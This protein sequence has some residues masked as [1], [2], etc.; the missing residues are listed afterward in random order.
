MRRADWLIVPLLAMGGV[1]TGVAGQAPDVV[2]AQPSQSRSTRTS[3]RCYRSTV[4]GAIARERSR[5]CRFSPTRAVSVGESHQDGRGQQE[6]AAW[7]CRPGARTLLEQSKWSTHDEI[8]TL[9]RWV[10]E[11]AVLGEPAAAPASVKWP[12]GWQITPDKIV[13]AGVY[14]PGKG[15]APSPPLLARRIGRARLSN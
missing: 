8:D 11:G 4:S 13:D 5:R 1:L 2:V 14:H 7:F 12:E 6:D 9:V 10:D 3:F 15:N